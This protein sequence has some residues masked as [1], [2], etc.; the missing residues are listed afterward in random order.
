MSDFESIPR[1]SLINS[2]TAMSKQ[3]ITGDGDSS[4]T[5]SNQ[6][7]ASKCYDLYA[8]LNN[9]P[10]LRQTTREDFCQESFFQKFAYYMT[11]VYRTKQHAFLMCGTVLCY[12]G[13][14]MIIGQNQLFRGKLE[15][16]S[17]CNRLKT[18]IV[19]L[20]WCHRGSVL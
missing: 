2:W 6:D 14:I 19:K 16:M 10:P 20:I 4:S 13:C 15:D 8:A 9:L 1:N 11:S 18:L 3:M 5:L 12:I 7:S 17:H